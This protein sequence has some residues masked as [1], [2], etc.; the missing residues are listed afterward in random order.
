MKLQLLLTLTAIILSVA[1]VGPA[2]AQSEADKI[3][4]ERKALF[5]SI[6]EDL[7]CE[8][9]GANPPQNFLDAMAADGFVREETRAIV[10]EL[11]SEGLAER[12]G[13]TLVL[14][15]ENCR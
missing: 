6:I 8:M 13:A 5:V 4:P 9:D 3:D 1:S 10:R 7:G 15:T 14:K 2:L 12:D 11:A